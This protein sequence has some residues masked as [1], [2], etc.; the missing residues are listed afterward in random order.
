MTSPP[1]A[2]ELH[3]LRAPAALFDGNGGLGRY[4]LLPGDRSRAERLGQRLLGV[5]RVENPRGHAVILGQ[6]PRPGR[7]GLDVAVVSTGMGT[8][9]AEIIMH[10]LLSAGVTRML[11]VGSCGSLSPRV[12]PGGV[13]IVSGAVRDEMTSRHY[14]PIELP[15]LSDPRVVA[16][17]SAAAVDIG[18]GGVTTVGLCHTKASLYAREFGEGPAGEQNRAYQAWLARC[19]VISSEMEASALFILAT[20]AGA[21][22][23]GPVAGPDGR[24]QAGAVLAVYGGGD[25]HMQLDEAKVALAEAR[26]ADLAFAGLLRWADQDG[27]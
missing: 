7:P 9:S 14:A 6:L 26:M 5:S 25:S 15:A 16:A 17:L 23:E 8:G 21:G 20:A 2:H 3:H 13:V 1:P 19:G 27:R 10:E 18:L 12:Q 11:R 4:A 24:V 22:R